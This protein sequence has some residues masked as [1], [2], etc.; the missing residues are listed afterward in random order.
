MRRKVRERRKELEKSQRV[1]KRDERSRESIFNKLG[2]RNEKE[3]HR[4]VERW[5]QFRVFS[6]RQ[7]T[8][9]EKITAVL[10]ERITQEQ[11]EAEL[12]ENEDGAI[13]VRRESALERFATT[14]Y[15]LANCM[16]VAGRL[17]KR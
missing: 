15:A 10:A 9:S 5:R 6:K 2:V 14:A 17:S 4:S 13:E 7:A 16:N 3:F 12:I 11:L 8:L 1:M